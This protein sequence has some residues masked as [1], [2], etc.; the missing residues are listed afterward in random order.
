MVVL[1]LSEVPEAGDILR[2]VADDKAARTAVETAEGQVAAKGGD[3]SG[4]ATLEDLY[5]QIQAGQA[6]ELRIILKSDVSGSLGAI[7]HALE[8]LDQD[9]VR[10][11]VLH[12]AAGD[13]T[14]NDIMLAT[15]SNAIVVGFNTSIT[16]T[17]RRAAEA[18]GVDVRL[19]DII[20][21]LTDDIDAALKGLL[22][23]EEVEVVEGRAEVRQV[24]R[25]G[26]NTVI[27]GSYVTDGRIVRCERADLARRQGH[28][29][30]PDR[31]VAALPR[32]RARG[33]DELRVRHR[34]G[35]V[36]RHRGRRRH[37]VLLD[38]DRQPGRRDG[39]GGA[40]SVTQRTDRIDELLRQEIG[41]IVTREVADPRVGFATITKVETTPDLRHAKVWV[42]VIGQPK[43][44]SATIAALGRAMPFVRHELG[45]TLRIKRIPDLHVELDD[46]AE[47]GTRVLQLLD[48]LESG[49]P[50]PR[51]ELPEGETLPTPVARVHHEGDAT[52]E[53][54]SAV[55]P[56]KP[57][58]RRGRAVEGPRQDTAHDAD[59]RRPGAIPRTR[60]PTSSSSGS[61]ARDASSRSATRTPTRTRSGRR[62]ASSA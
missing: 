49:R 26:K 41:S 6:K 60:C 10:I 19:Y 42:S 53:P 36:P 37:R 52:E 16:E 24:I 18:E 22:E 43:E 46:T 4:R 47:R 57:R 3:G 35:L 61:A 59:D 12:E 8:Q 5:R 48:E 38:A 58:R 51:S 50:G 45:K 56:P 28:R 20:Y 54:P 33:P 14:D 34:S 62:S 27:A 31:V 32:R 2:V 25:V 21:K 15:A 39:L 29:D 13:I 30:R 11:N 9:E 17:A 7:T 55:I 23:P 1:G 44:R 40:A